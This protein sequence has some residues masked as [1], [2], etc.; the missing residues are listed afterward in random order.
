MNDPQ[1]LAALKDV[2]DPEMSINIVDFGLVYRAV[3]TA[4][5]IE[6]SIGVMST[7]P[8][9]G[10]LV[11]E[12][13]TALRR[14]F[15]DVA[16]IHVELDMER[17]WCPDRLTDEGRLALGWVAAPV[18]PKNAPRHRATPR[19]RASKAIMPKVSR[20]WTQ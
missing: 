8:A 15:P 11:A 18:T 16:H 1:V 14:R 6:V 7:C 5:R 20:R 13:R 4:E 12:A 10:V 2:L 17:P 3:R 19:P 9:M